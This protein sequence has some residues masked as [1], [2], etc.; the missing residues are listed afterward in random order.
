MKDDGNERRRG[1]HHAS[2]IYY[3]NLLSSRRHVVCVSSRLRDGAIGTTGTNELAG[4]L[5]VSLLR[6]PTGLSFLWGLG[7]GC[8]WMP[9]ASPTLVQ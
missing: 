2:D 8:G 7:M 5:P 3:S 6:N 1:G 4:F 9:D